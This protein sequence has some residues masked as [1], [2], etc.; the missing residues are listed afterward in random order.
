MDVVNCEL[1]DVE[2]R[3]YRNLGVYPTWRT[4]SGKESEEIQASR[5]PVVD[6][7]PLEES[8]GPSEKQYE[9]I[10]EDDSFCIRISADPEVLFVPAY[11]NALFAELRSIIVSPIHGLLL[12]SRGS[13]LDQT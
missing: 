8:G 6:P 1:I 12:Q 10:E 4:R 2:H 13:N 5:R 9:I 11:L 7:Q 3:L